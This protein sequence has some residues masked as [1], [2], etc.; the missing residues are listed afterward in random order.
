MLTI[1][2]DSHSAAEVQNGARPV[3]VG[4]E[5]SPRCKPCL[6][7]RGVNRNR[8]VQRALLII[9]SSESTAPDYC[10]CAPLVIPDSSGFHVLAP[11]P[12]LRADDVPARILC[13][14][15]F[16]EVPPPRY[17]ISGLVERAAFQ[18]VVSPYP[19]AS[20]TWRA[21]R[22]VSPFD[23]ADLALAGGIS[24]SMCAALMCVCQSGFRYP[25]SGAA[26]RGTLQTC[27]ICTVQA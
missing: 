7:S 25:R 22:K 12:L 8:L 10:V 27:C 15:V 9:L 16:L 14:S 24:G 21:K 18:A 2:R 26:A 17:G 5:R 13:G 23:D 6:L 11:A 1:Y 19:A 20:P 4:N 3:L